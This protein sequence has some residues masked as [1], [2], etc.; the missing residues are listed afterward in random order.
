MPELMASLPISGVDGT[1]RRV[2][3]RAQGS[4]HLKTGSLGDVVA[5]A[6]YV[7]G[8]GGKRYVLV[9]LVNHPNARAARPAI[10]ALVEWATLER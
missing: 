3:S 4:A 8:T 2:R 7:H 9:A 5:V 6:G 1:L 10:D